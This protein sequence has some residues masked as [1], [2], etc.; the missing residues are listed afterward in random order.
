M[1]SGEL[2]ALAPGLAHSVRA[3]AP[4]ELLLTVHRLPVDEGTP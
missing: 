2:M 3:L 1:A 4:S